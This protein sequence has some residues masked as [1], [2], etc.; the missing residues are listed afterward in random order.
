TT[1][2]LCCSAP[3]S[4]WPCPTRRP[5]PLPPPITSS[6]A[7]RTSSGFS[8]L[9]GSSAEGG[10]GHNEAVERR[11]VAPQD[12]VALVFGHVGRVFLDDGLAVGERGIAVRMI[13]GPTQPLVMHEMPGLDRDPI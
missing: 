6:T 4:E 2:S 10:L 5:R 11:G 13:A 12:V 8:D 3:L 1:T 9:S 7:G